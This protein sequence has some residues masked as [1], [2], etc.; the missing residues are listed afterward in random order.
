MQQW[1]GCVVLVMYF[2]RREMDLVLVG[3]LT[4]FGCVCKWINE[5]E[6][7]KRDKQNDAY[8]VVGSTV[9]Q[10]QHRGNLSSFC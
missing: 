9:A 10:R 6:P 3:G 5:H 4:A 1:C 2:V 8:I 7:S